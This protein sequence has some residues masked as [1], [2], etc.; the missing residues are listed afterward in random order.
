MVIGTQNA[1]SAEAFLAGGGVLGAIIAGFDWSR[2]PLGPIVFWPTSIKTT[3]GLILRSPVPIVTLWGEAGIMIYNDA[4]SE[5]AG[6]RHPELL[7]SEVRKGW[8]EVA[9]FNDNVMK[10]GLSGGTLSY[11]DQELALQRRGVLEP[12]W[13]NLDYSPV[14]GE[15]GKPIGIIAIVVETTE[16]VKMERQLRA[17]E[18][19]L[20]FLDQ[21]SKATAAERDADAV[22]KVTTRM[23]GE[24]LGVSNC[25]YA[26]MDEDQDGFTIRGD[27]AAP[28]AMHILGHY[29]L[30][31]FGKRAVNDLHAGRPLIINDNLREL[32]PEEAATFQSIG[33][34]STICMPLVKEGRLTALM[35]IHHKDPHVWTADELALL[36]EV[37][38]RSWAHIER[39]RAEAETLRAEQEYR[40]KLAREVAD[41]TADFQQS[42]KNLRTVF[43]TSYLN[44]G[45]LTVDGMIVYVNAT[46][47]AAIDRR[48]EDVVGMDYADS[49]WFENSPGVRDKV[50]DGIARAAAGEHVQMSMALDLPKGRRLYEF[51]MRPALDEAGNVVALVPESVEITA[52]V[53]AEEALQQAIKLEAIG[54]LTGGIA[55]DFNNLLMAVLGSLELLRKR[56]PADPAL[57]RLVDNASEGARRGK[58][59]TER[60]L[61]FARKQDLKPE[62]VD[63]GELIGGMADLMARALGPTI[64]VNIETDR[65]LPAVEI[66]PNQLEAAILNLAVN[67]RDAMNGEG[68]IVIGARRANGG[69][70]QGRLKPGPYVV[71]TMS[72]AGAGMDDATLRRATEPFFTTKGIGK[73]TGLGLSMVHGLA[74]QSGGTLILHSTVGV[75]TTAEIWLP[76]VAAAP[77]ASLTGDVQQPGLPV[78]MEMAS[79]LNILAV[80][81]DPL[82]LMNTVEML[83][84]MGHAVVGASSARQALEQFKSATFDLI[85]TDHAMPHTTGA[86]LVKELRTL[87]PDLPI[88]LATGYAELPAEAEIDVMRLRKPYSQAD[89]VEA[90]ARSR[91]GVASSLV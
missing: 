26:D 41:R 40:Q 50:R 39:V 52:R 87:R 42:E 23:T 77:R 32:A 89:L 18:A 7:G 90:V 21:L 35:A 57:L 63:L 17:N 6:G 64:S 62:R 20:K 55:H 43:E 72:D 75:G 30:A 12:V 49:P 59:L 48:L 86:Q 91:F 54:N 69:E 36:A 33:I 81:D 24:H 78:P 14:I 71:L 22:M 16:R 84:D 58:S 82:V 10:V 25:A 56:M 44:Q 3:V 34:S 2:T 46:S 80:D 31:D 5:F 8:P 70:L 79:R 67:A 28:G 61:A 60:M 9:D 68:P 88:I 47:L 66:D 45:L 38:E 53:R 11:Q 29:S 65:N 15:G 51:S 19:R 76:A 85:I 74:E 37:T 1:G 73:G 83:E 27:W 13:M 4:Y